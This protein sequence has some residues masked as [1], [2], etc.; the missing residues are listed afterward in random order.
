MLEYCNP[1]WG[2]FILDRRKIENVQHRATHLIPSVRE[3]TYSKRLT[4]LDLPSY[5]KL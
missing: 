1:I 3:N 2:I 5:H 4:I